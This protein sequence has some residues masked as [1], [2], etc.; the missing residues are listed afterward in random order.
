MIPVRETK[1]PYKIKTIS[2]VDENGNRYA[3]DFRARVYIV[4]PEELEELR[5]IGYSFTLRYTEKGE[6]LYYDIDQGY[7]QVKGE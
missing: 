6:K 1:Y 4:T 3:N 5:E 2:C 7:F